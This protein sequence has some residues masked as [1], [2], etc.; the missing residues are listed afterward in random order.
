MT[1]GSAI[2]QNVSFYPQDIAL[3]EAVQKR[4]GAGFSGAVRFIIRDWQRLVDPQ[5]TLTSQPDPKSKTRP[6]KVTRKSNQPIDAI[7]GVRKG[8]PVA[9]Q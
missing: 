3:V 7:D 8:A 9:N 6:R 1:D 5:G 2:N 4:N